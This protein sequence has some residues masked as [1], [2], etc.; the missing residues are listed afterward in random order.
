MPDLGQDEDKTPNNTP[1]EPPHKKQRPVVKA[2]KEAQWGT[3]SKDS[4]VVRAAQ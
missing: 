4:E 1:E 3:F 2:F